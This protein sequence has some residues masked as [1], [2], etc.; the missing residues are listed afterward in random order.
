MVDHAG[1]VAHLAASSSF[2]VRCPRRAVQVAAAGDPSAEGAVGGGGDDKEGAPRI[3]CH[4][5]AP[6]RRRAAHAQGVGR[7]DALSE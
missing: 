3:K 7:D 6:L 4:A 5:A 1:C 2:Q